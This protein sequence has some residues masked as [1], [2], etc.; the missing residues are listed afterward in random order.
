MVTHIYTKLAAKICC[1]YPIV[2]RVGVVA[3]KLKLH[4]GSRVHPVFHI[5]LLK[6]ATGNY[7]E[8]EELPD[9]LEGDGH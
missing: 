7:N 6:K 3:Y 1:P 4:E 2:A 9:H 8:E 5:S